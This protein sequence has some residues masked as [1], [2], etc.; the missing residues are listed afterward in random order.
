MT[1]LDSNDG[2]KTIPKE[3]CEKAFDWNNPKE[4]KVKYIA[5]WIYKYGISQN[6]IPMK[7]KKT[8]EIELKRLK[9]EEEEKKIKKM[10]E[11]ELAS[12]DAI[13][14]NEISDYYL[15][16][17]LFQTEEEVIEANRI[18]NELILKE[19]SKI[20][21]G[22]RYKDNNYA[23]DV[24]QFNKDLNNLAKIYF[25]LGG[26]HT[27][28]K[29]MVNKLPEPNSETLKQ[30]LNKDRD[31]I[32]DYFFTLGIPKTRAIKII[33]AIIQQALS[34]IYTLSRTEKKLHLETNPK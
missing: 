1:D 30:S 20:E 3:Q 19:Q 15:D 9:V 29:E 21:N 31:K 13:D 4:V 2:Y 32:L 12:Y 16:P 34:S 17:S 6:R 33:T 10:I 24:S 18:L 22:Y 5:Y 26:S 27:L 28:F 14:S 23:R 25:E 8:V 11:L 7:R